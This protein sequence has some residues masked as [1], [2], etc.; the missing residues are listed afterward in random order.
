MGSE[1]F[2]RAR[3]LFDAASER[4]GDERH[5]FLKDACGFDQ[6]LL[7]RVERLLRFAEPEEDQVRAGEEAAA[8][9]I[10]ASSNVESAPTTPH[11]VSVGMLAP[12]FDLPSTSVN[13]L[14]PC[15][16]SL[17]CFRGRW[18]VLVFYPRDF[19]LVCPTE[20]TALSNRMEEFG[21]C[22]AD[23]LGVSVDSIESHER[24]LTT[25]TAHRGLGGL[26][27]PL[28]SDE[29][30]AV[31]RVYG[32]Y[33]EQQ[34]VSLRGLFLIDPNGVLQYQ[35]VHNLNVGRRSDEILRVLS[36]LQ[37]GGLCAEDWTS[38]M[39]AVDPTCV[40]CPGN[41]VSHY[42]IEACVG[43]GAFGSVFRA[44]DTI[45]KRTVA[46]KV[47]KPDNPLSAGAVLDEARAAAALNHMNICTIFAVDDSEG[48]P[49][50]AM[51]YVRGQ[52]L[53]EL[54]EAGPVPLD[55]TANIARQVAMGMAAAHAMGISHGDL[56]PAN[57]IVRDDGVVKILDFGLARLGEGLRDTRTA[58]T[59]KAV[60]TGRLRG[61]PSYMSPAQAVGSR[62]TRK[63]DVFALG[64]MLYELVTGE[65]AFEG[66][67][68]PQILGQVQ[69]VDPGKLAAAVPEPFATVVRGALVRD[70]RDRVITME[71]IAEV[72]G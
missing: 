21:R 36:A 66:E 63:C 27:F 54:I 15:R 43:V 40:L 10:G 28:A 12:D 59:I 51:E 35:A 39:A 17:S 30:G 38:G 64:V 4:S 60:K 3:E 45:L 7:E 31:S 58:S 6:G 68:I 62:A 19:S 26:R 44:Q 53:S 1:G 57:V 46:L 56:K 37:M 72:L 2:K 14:A 13:S 67:T 29:D 16:V 18:L 33:L 47:L 11:G 34:H 24:W 25:P 41:M 49:F 32:V 22:G 55:K 70:A 71:R 23:I 20:L 8:P 65:A 42:R 50:I 69:A 9:L 61:T 48:V 52:S 5:A